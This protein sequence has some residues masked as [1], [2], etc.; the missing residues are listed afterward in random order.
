MAAMEN[1]GRIS[2]FTEGPLV[3]HQCDP[4]EKTEFIAPKNVVRRAYD[5]VRKK[6]VLCAR[7]ANRAEYSDWEVLK[8]LRDA[9]I[10]EKPPSPP[11]PPPP[12]GIA[13]LRPRTH[14]PNQR[15]AAAQ[16]NWPGAHSR[17]AGKLVRLPLEVSLVWGGN[18]NSPRLLSAPKQQ[19]RKSFASPRVPVPA[20]KLAGVVGGDFS[21]GGGQHAGGG[22]GGGGA[23]RAPAPRAQSARVRVTHTALSRTTVMSARSTAGT[24]DAG[25]NADAN[26]NANDAAPGHQTTQ[27]GGASKRPS[28]APTS[29]RTPR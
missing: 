5:P 10:I 2:S 24:G 8:M 21:D 3:V 26:I 9:P 4:F 15:A 17:E 20:L 29:G 13:S 22:G 11:P 27:S 18:P 7:P 14:Y 19:P 1:H 16:K 12:R 6:N 25:G 28:S 23:S